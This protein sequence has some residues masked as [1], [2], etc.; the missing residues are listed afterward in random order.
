MGI[1]LFLVL[2]GIVVDKMEVVCFNLGFVIRGS[3]VRY[4]GSYF[5]VINY[6]YVIV[7]ECCN[8][9]FL[10]VFMNI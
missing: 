4:G 1:I 9:I 8:S 7:M 5:S 2:W 10:I 3:V 6:S